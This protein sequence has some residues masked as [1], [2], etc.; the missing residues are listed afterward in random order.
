MTQPKIS[1]IT[2]SFN[3]AEFLEET[4]DSVLSQDYK[5]LEYIIIDGGSNDESID[6][7]KKHEKY[8]T[9]WVSE[10]DGGQSEAINKGL[11]LITGGICNWL[12]SDDTLTKNS[13][14]S[15]AYNFNITNFDVYIGGHN[16]IGHNSEIKRICKGR[17]LK[18]SPEL[19][20]VYTPMTQPCT[21]FKAEFFKEFGYLSKSLHYLMDFEIW[22][23]YLLCYGQEKIIE[24]R[25]NTIAN[26]RLHNSSKTV[27][28][29]D[30]SLTNFKSKFMNDK[31]N[32]FYSLSK[33][34]S[35]EKEANLLKSCCSPFLHN[36]QLKMP[37]NYNLEVSKKAV[38]YYLFEL[39][40]LFFYSEYFSEAM[41][42]LNVI[43]KS[44]LTKENQRDYSYLKR[45][46]NIKNFTKFFKAE[47]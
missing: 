9:Y 46:I 40:K 19:S 33:E 27:N 32:V 39:A 14:K 47:K 29:M 7:I 2:P 43:N 18:D 15:I 4:I 1:I 30:I 36:Y 37:K 17:P 22:L 20:V 38:T 28:E 12:C 25:T 21:F 34:L 35:L 8:L 45:S 23:K 6:I 11:R 41:N 10:P 5:N 24:E 26:Y 13:L 16:I 31:V 42:C 44:F 3:Q